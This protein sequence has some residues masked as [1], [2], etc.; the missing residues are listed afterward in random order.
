MFGVGERNHLFVNAEKGRINQQ[1][2]TATQCPETLGGLNWVHFPLKYELLRLSSPSGPNEVPEASWAYRPACFVLFLFLSFWEMEHCCLRCMCRLF[3]LSSKASYFHLTQVPCT[4]F[5]ITVPLL[6]TPC[7][8]VSLW[9]R[10]QPC[11]PNSC[12]S[13]PKPLAVLAHVH[14][15]SLILRGLWW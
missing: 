14:P 11:S 7:C 8:F 2:S 15:V 5:Q 3:L 9:R 13:L 4:I 10:E 6:L 1:P 12:A